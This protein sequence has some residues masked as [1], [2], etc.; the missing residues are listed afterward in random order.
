MS[1]VTLWGQLRTLG[2][3]P[4]SLIPLKNPVLLQVWR[5]APPLEREAR[6]DVNC[7]RP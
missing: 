1:V 2:S 3:T 5:Q 6:R 7:Y 4:H